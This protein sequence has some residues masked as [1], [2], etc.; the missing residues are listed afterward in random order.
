MPLDQIDGVRVVR[1]GTAIE[2]GSG[3]STQLI[4]GQELARQ[5][6]P[7]PLDGITAAAISPR[8]IELSL[9][10]GERPVFNLDDHAKALTKATVIIRGAR[11]AR[12]NGSINDSD[13][14]PLGLEAN[15]AL[16]ANRSQ[17]LWLG[18]SRD[19]DRCELDLDDAR[20]YNAG[21]RL[22]SPGLVDCHTHLIFAGDRADEFALRARGAS[23]REIAES[24]GG[25][26]A[27]L[28]PTRAASAAELLELARVR[29]Q[30]C[31]AAG[32]TTLEAKSGYDLTVEGELRLLE[33]LGALDSIGPIDIEPTLLG[34]HLVPPEYKDSRARYVTAVTTEMIPRAAAARLCTSVDVYCDQGAFTRAETHDIFT[35]ATA[36][37]LSVRAHVGQFCDLGGA[38]LV[39][40]CGGLSA[41]HLEQISAAGIQQLANR[42]TVAVMLPGACVQLRQTPPPVAALRA[43]GVALAVASD[44]NPGSSYCQSLATPM[45]LATTHYQMSVEET[46]LGVT[47]MAAR[48]LGRTDIGTLAVGNAADFVIWDCDKPADVA[49]RFS[50]NL[51][52]WVFKAGEQIEDHST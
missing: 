26:A 46:W 28:V 44:L 33:I 8:G 10:T 37:G 45:W 22:L 35:A 19:L 3:H 16:V 38:E 23:Y 39:A 11:L 14:N 52:K 25:I 50:T 17:I 31:L 7:Q 32:T 2:L 21:G 1:S 18:P 5:I 24:G 20:E 43:G 34:A 40:E 12:C 49:Y 29:A 13:D 41:D 36:H 15:T 42:G 48:A 27:T 9:A 51:A 6:G 4:R 30:R 47:Q